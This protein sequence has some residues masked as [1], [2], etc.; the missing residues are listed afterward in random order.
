MPPI[1]ISRPCSSSVCQ[2]ESER[3]VGIIDSLSTGYRFVSQRPGLL[4]LPL[5]LDALLWVMPRWSIGPLMQRMADFFGKMVEDPRMMEGNPFALPQTVDLMVAAGQT[6]NLAQFLVNGLL[7]H[8][9]SLL[10][11]LPS[12]KGGHPSV[13]I[14]SIGTA[15]LL[16]LFFGLVGLLIGATYMNLLA[17]SLPIGEGRKTLSLNSLASRIV[18]H[19]LRTIG[20]LLFVTL[21]LTM[22]Y[23]PGMLGITVLTL[24]SP[25]L[26]S[27]ALFLF[28]G[29]IVVIMF[30]L[31]FVTTALVLDDL[32]IG[33]AVRRSIH[34]VRYNFWHTVGFVLLTSL[35][36]LGMGL[37][38]YRITQLHTLGVALAT[39]GNTFVGTGLA[40]SLLVFYRTRILAMQQ[41]E[42]QWRV[43]NG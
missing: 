5:L 39:L 33:Q 14:D 20:F 10:A 6:S 32:A 7:Y 28:I 36:S 29:L 18:R 41:E 2:L 12:I 26:G 17:Q 30:Y 35:I 11:A 21:G 4:L 16:S 23:I 19:W 43:N 38:F 25:M 27:A 22:I 3:A 42:P 24:I 37:L 34:L 31:Y 9:P 1:A 15:G 8:V 13:E 40:M